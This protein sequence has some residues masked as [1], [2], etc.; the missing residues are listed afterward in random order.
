MGETGTVVGL[1]AQN[2]Q[3]WM[4]GGAMQALWIVQVKLDRDE[5]I[6]EYRAD[7]LRKVD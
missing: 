1:Y 5:T 3:Q 6:V 7:E 4:V 2:S